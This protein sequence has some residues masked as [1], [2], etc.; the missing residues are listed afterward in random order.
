M[1]RLG[2]RESLLLFFSLIAGQL[3]GGCRAT[4]VPPGA[5]APGDARHSML[6]GRGHRKSPSSRHAGRMGRGGEGAAGRPQKTGRGPCSAPLPSGSPQANHT[7]NP[8]R[9]SFRISETHTP[10]FFPASP[11]AWSSGASEAPDAPAA[12]GAVGAGA[13]IQW[14]ERGGPGLEGRSPGF[15]AGLC[16]GFLGAVLAHRSFSDSRDSVGSASCQALLL[17]AWDTAGEAGPLPREPHPVGGG[18]R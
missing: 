3:G 8:R 16:T 14:M 12:A 13:W 10:H 7:H 5:L 4:R 18:G 9:H 11:T 15:P 6:W 2:E 17:G 1:P